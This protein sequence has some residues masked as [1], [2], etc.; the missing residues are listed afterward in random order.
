MRE[1]F[2]EGFLWTCC[3][4]MGDGKGCRPGKHELDPTL[5]TGVGHYPETDTEIEPFDDDEDEDEEESQGG[6]DE[7]D[8]KEEEDEENEPVG[9]D[10]KRKRV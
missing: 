5:A 10:L 3:Q 1:E 2:P 4:R 7:V 9:R 8:I 6:E